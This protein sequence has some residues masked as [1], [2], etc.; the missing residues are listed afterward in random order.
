[1]NEPI[2]SIADMLDAIETCIKHNQISL[3][4]GEENFVISMQER[5]G[6]GR[7]FTD[8]QR[9]VISDLYDKT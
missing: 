4:E 8:K 5:A 9:Q 1:M 3:T 7:G 2:I 6:A